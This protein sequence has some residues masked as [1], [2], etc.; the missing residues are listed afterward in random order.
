MLVTI[1]SLTILIIIF[2]KRKKRKKREKKKRKRNKKLKQ[3]KQ[4]PSITI[5][6]KVWVWAKGHFLNAILKAHLFKFG[7][8]DSYKVSRQHI[9]KCI[10]LYMSRPEPNYK[11]RHVTIAAR[12]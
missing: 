10:A 12:L 2:K 11:D 1:T 6:S 9:G 7:V 8:V 4:R 5:S 3:R